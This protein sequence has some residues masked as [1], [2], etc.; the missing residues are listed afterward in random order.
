[1]QTAQLFDN[2]Y[3]SRPEFLNGTVLFHELCGSAIP[4]NSRILEIGSGPAN[5]TTEWLAARF[6]IAGLDVSEEVHGNRHLFESKTFDGNLFPFPDNSFDGCVSSY[7]LEHVSNPETHFREIARVLKP[8]APYCFRTPNLWH[9]VTLA[10]YLLPH[11][12]H[13]MLA[14]WARRRNGEAHDPWPTLYLANT[15]KKLRKS[16]HSAGLRMERLQMV[17]CEPCYGAAHPILFYPMMAYERIVN[18]TERMAALRVN[19]FGVMRKPANEQAAI[20]PGK[21]IEEPSFA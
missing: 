19:I 14:N 20:E 10:S 6:S 7:V 17:E 13:L 2:Y 18:M 8:G 5:T 21:P 9:Y 11:S 1:M 15:R 3:F 16:A 12:A 4:E